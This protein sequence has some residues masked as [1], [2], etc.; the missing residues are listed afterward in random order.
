MHN[1]SQPEKE[2]DIDVLF[3]NWRD[4]RHPEGG[5]SEQ[6]VHRVAEGLAAAGLRVRLFCAAH[7]RAPADE[8]V[9][10][11]QVVRRGGRFGVYPRGLAH[12][13][14]HRPRLVVDVQNG[15]PFAS[16]LVTRAPVVVLLHHVHREQW[17]ILFGPRLGA[18]GWWVESRFAPWVY[19]G[20]RYVTVSAATADE[21][22]DLG[23]SPDRITVVH[24][25]VDPGPPVAVPPAAGPRLVTVGRLVPHKRVEHAIDV[26]ARLRAGH[27]GLTLDV[28]GE[29]WWGGRLRAHARERGVDDLVRFHGFVDERTKHE[30]LAGAWL[31]LCPSV[32][33]GWGLVVTEAAGH[34]VPTVAYR[35]AGGLRESVLDGR[36]GVL[37]D[38]LDAMV[39]AVDRLLTDPRERAGLGAAARHR[40]GAR[41]W[42]ATALAFG[43]V[44]AESRH[45]RE[46][47][48]T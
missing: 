15:I 33:E 10:G 25:G 34:G 29:G 7:D 1:G 41:T 8:V 4:R 47:D 37:V 6:Y 42:R 18:L 31:H 5:G 20:C 35:S 46:G 48:R 22:A 11:V 24:N 44:L 38:D 26:V 2:D 12:V 32:K 21:L 45:D 19:R 36:T 43:E 39:T 23:V 30:L 16:P 27:P 17:P 28:V 40:A 3:L 14:R 9:A 13:R